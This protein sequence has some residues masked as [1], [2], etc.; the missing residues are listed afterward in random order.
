[1]KLVDHKN[2]FDGGG[3]QTTI[4]DVT[5]RIDRVIKTSSLKKGDTG[6]F[7]I[8]IDGHDLT[9]TSAQIQKGSGWFTTLYYDA[10]GKMLSIDKKDWPVFA[11][12]IADIAEQ[13][14]LDE[15]NA[16]MAADM[17]LEQLCKGSD[18][19]EDKSVLLDGENCSFF[20]KHRPHEELFYV[21]PAS[22]VGAMLKDEI[23]V[24]ATLEDVSQAMTARGYKREKTQGVKVHGQNVWCWW[25][26]PEKIH[27]Q[28]PS[29]EEE[30]YED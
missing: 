23:C 8:Y 9:L 15:T 27:N 1:M 10:F 30:D 6:K 28:N 12:Y 29:I 14:D 4:A 13:G 5:D 16:V 11:E 20:V 22:A 17:L 26:I 24:Q 7:H 25:F 19:T 21:V 18:I 3:K 2:P